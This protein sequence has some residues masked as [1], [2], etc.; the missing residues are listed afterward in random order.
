MDS[1]NAG[2][3][4]TQNGA[5]RIAPSSTVPIPPPTYQTHNFN[6]TRSFQSYATVVE[7][8]G[9]DY[10]YR[11]RTTT[12]IAIAHDKDEEKKL[13]EKDEKST[14][15][16]VVRSMQPIPE[17]GGT[18]TIAEPEPHRYLHGQKLVLV[19]IGFLLG[20]FVAT[21][22]QSMVST[23]LP[24]LASQFHALDRLTW[25]ISAFFRECLPYSCLI[26]SSYLLSLHTRSQHLEHNDD[27]CLLTFF[28]PLLF[29]LS[30][31]HIASLHVSFLDL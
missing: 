12:P 2:N 24:Q 4:T 17:A 19:T 10:E 15:L 28:S 31:S 5:H 20:D 11:T 16:S 23:A 22:D 6:T 26:P 8:H 14:G 13:G 27:G 18:P 30:R 25:V 3:S 7:S 9:L 29:L 21:L 1:S